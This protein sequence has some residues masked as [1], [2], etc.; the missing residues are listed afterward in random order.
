MFSINKQLGLVIGAIAAAV[1]MIFILLSIL[2]RG[3][4]TAF[5]TSTWTLLFREIEKLEKGGKNA[6]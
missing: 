5:N 6:D 4:Y 1:I 2:L 3:I